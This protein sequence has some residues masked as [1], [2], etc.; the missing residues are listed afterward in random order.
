MTLITVQNSENCLLEQLSAK[1]PILSRAL[2]PAVGAFLAAK[3]NN[4][5]IVIGENLKQ[6]VFIVE[7]LHFCDAL[8]L[9]LK[10]TFT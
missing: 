5:Q 10:R 8:L 6:N 7:K 1:S 9:Y 4:N 3:H 2:V